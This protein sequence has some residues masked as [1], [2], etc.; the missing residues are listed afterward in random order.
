VLSD[1]ASLLRQFLIVLKAQQHMR[2]LTAIGDDRRP[3][4]RRFFRPGHVLIQLP[5]GQGGDGHERDLAD[6]F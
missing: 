6:D 2:G 5:A 1:V 4:A 3:L